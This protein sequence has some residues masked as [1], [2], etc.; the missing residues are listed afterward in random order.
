MIQVSNEFKKAIKQPERRIKGHVEVLY[1]LPSVEITTTTS[2]I[3]T[4]SIIS[5]IN[6]IT[7][8]HR[9][10]NLYGSLDYLP[11]DGSYLTAT[12]DSKNSGFISSN[13]FEDMTTPT[14]TLSFSSTT[15]KGI[16]MYFRT[17]IPTDLTINYSDGTSTTIQENE[18]EIIQVIFD[19]PKT[20]TGLDIVINDMEY[21]DRKIYLMEIDLG[22]TQVYKDQDLIEFTVDEEVNKLV[23]EVPIN[24][25]NIT[26]NN[27]SDLFNP[28]NSK[29][30]VPYLS[31]NTLIKPYI[32]VL[33]ETQGVE[34]VKM[35]EFYLDSYTNN[36]DAT[37]TLV[38]K[39]IIKQLEGEILKDDNETDIFFPIIN[40]TRLRSFLNNYNY[41]F[42]TLNIIRNS[43]V[44]YFK[45]NNLLKMLKDI[46]FYQD[47]LFYSNRDSQI[48][49]NKQN[50]NMVDSITKS[51]LINDAE[52]KKID[53]INTIKLIK[54]NLTSNTESSQK[55]VL[56][57]TIILK[58]TSEVVLLQSKG[59][60]LTT[61]TISQTGGSSALIISQ[62]SYMVFAKLQGSVGDAINV[63]LSSN[64]SSNE[65][66]IELELTNRG[67][68][69][70]VSLEFNSPVNVSATG[71][72]GYIEN[73]DILSRTPSYEMRF[74]YNG[75]PSL[76]AGDYINVETPYGYKPLFI[77]KNRFK[78]DGG[79]EGSIEGVE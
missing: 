22:I 47:D 43:P 32:G 26:L 44:L 13:L 6:E 27:M 51:E 48:I 68:Q 67:E 60:D 52:Y 66:Q 76:E 71:G 49:M 14:F 77:Q 12:V 41:N 40:E 39:N 25:T 8:G 35:G 10:E 42:T 9:V 62:G 53:K 45:D 70:E 46:S 38:G 75:D 18:K 64:L 28:L 19:S 37:T 55:E 3:G 1:D 79:L 31:E 65:S 78:F 23:E 4:T 73:S 15:I 59:A 2:G 50:N 63:T 5:N 30:I 36:S 56:K 24:E 21:Q 69:K 72:N 34:Y 61:S 17:N 29:G 54:P 11:L 74:D 20:L 7:D 58:Q 57:E 16:T 33:T